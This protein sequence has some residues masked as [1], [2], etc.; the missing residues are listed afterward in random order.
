MPAPREQRNREDGFSTRLAE[1]VR[2]ALS[3][4][5]VP[6]CSI[7]VV[8]AD[9]LRWADGFG[10][11][12]LRCRRRA[13]ADTVYHLFSGTKLFTAVA[14]L[15]LDE[16]GL[17]DLDDPVERFIPETG[18]AG[19]ASVL[20]LLSHQ[21]GLGDS[22][23]GFLSVSFPS[24][25]PQGSAEALARYALKV[26]RRPGQRVEYRNVNYALLGEVVT[27]VSGLEYRDYV[28][29]RVLAPLGM[30]ADFGLAPATRARAATGYL[31]R[32]DPMRLVLRA[33]FPGLGGRLYGDRVGKLME[34]REYDLATS[35]IGG[36]VGSM[37]DFA[38]FLQAQLAGGG[39]V[40]GQEATRRM[41]T[42]VATGVAGI[43]S[44][45]GVALGWKIGRTKGRAFL[46]HEGGGAGFTSELRLYPD[47]GLGIAL[48]MNAM[49]MPA[50]MRLADRICETIHAER[51]LLRTYRAAP[52]TASH[53][54]PRGE[55]Q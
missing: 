52:C 9:G 2:P 35:S 36:L 38:R 3:R 26:R 30:T 34:L 15:Q 31:G 8:D 10:Y 54:G 18:A 13:R 16:C 12:D 41:Q 11:A 19:R 5:G 33:L 42:Q 21:S 37:P 53:D 22:L 6:G 46:N 4:A 48:G 27:R 32:R 51:H 49:R 24:D 23:R 39:P 1:I 44:R 14:I 40:L 47:A 55:P 45:A 20:Q 17:L 29:R 28:R 25:P 7:A 43:A 50:T